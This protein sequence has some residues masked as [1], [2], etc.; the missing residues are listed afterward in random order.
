M[1]A[2]EEEEQPSVKAEKER[3]PKNVAAKRL[4]KKVADDPVG[5]LM[6][7]NLHEDLALHCETLER[8]GDGDTLGDRRHGAVEQYAKE[9]QQ[10]VGIAY[11]DRDKIRRKLHSELNL[12]ELT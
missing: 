11:Q 12:P 6:R 7:I 1:P 5:S 10:L 2:H 3:P 4:P 8:M 9:Y